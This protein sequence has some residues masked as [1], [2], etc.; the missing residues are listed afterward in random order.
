[1]TNRNYEN[2]IH[3]RFR[4]AVR[5]RDGY[6][7]AWPHCGE[8]RYWMLQVHHILPHATHIE[9]RFNPDNGITLCTK[10]HD[11]V[12]GNE[13]NFAQMLYNIARQNKQKGIK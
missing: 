1:M 7:C 11:V 2:K 4:R 6:K 13:L 10:H 9:L 8:S 5:K 12:T 3:Q